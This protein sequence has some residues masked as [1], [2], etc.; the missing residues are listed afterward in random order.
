MEKYKKAIRRA[1]HMFNYSKRQN[2]IS[3]AKV[4]NGEMQ[5]IIRVATYDNEISD[6]DFLR[7]M[8][9]HKAMTNKIFEM[10]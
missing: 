5:G 10:M 9:L 6:E 3:G 1:L 4:S 2:H 8:D 7:M